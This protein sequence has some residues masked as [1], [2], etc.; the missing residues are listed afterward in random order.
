MKRNNSYLQGVNHPNHKLTDEDVMRIRS[1]YR[2]GSTTQKDIAKEYGISQSRVCNI[3][4]GIGWSH[5]PG[6][7]DGRR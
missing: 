1:E 7:W 6:I 5:L 4:N 3:I 2:R